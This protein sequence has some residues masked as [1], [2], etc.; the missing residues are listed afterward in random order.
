MLDLVWLIPALPLAGFLILFF[1]GKKIGDPWAGILASAMLFG[2][3]LASVVV[4]IGLADRPPETREFVQ[5]LFSWMPVS[6]FQ[7]DIGFL[8][9]PLSTTM[10][11]FVTFVAFLIH[12]YSIRCV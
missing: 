6:G 9:D 3:F 2:S 12:L 5:N 10:V 1:F 4:T 7:V 8:V 11:L